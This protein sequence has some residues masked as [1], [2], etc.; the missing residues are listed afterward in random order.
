MLM[1]YPLENKKHNG[2]TALG[3]ATHAGDLDIIKILINSG[4]KV[5]N[6]NKSGVS[7]LTLA[8]KAN[9]SGCI[10]YLIKNGASIYFE[11]P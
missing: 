7:A 1:K 9:N 10:E 6:Y 11:D 3:I 4:C 8:I 5:N 2:I